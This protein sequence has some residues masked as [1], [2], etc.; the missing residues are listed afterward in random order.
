MPDRQL[1]AIMFTDIMGYTSLMNE[2]E[3]KALQIIDKN[4]KLHELSLKTYHGRLIKKMGD[5]TL[6]CFSSAIEAVQ[7]AISIQNEVEKYPQLNLRIGIH[8]GD[9]VIQENDIYGDGVNIAARIESLTGCGEIYISGQVYDS[10]RNHKEFRCTSIGER[11]LKNVGNPVMIYKVITSEKSQKETSNIHEITWDKSIVV[12][13]FDDLS[14]GKDNEYFSDGLIEE[15][16]TM[17]SQIHSLRVISRTSALMY[18]GKV[19]SVTAIGKELNVQHVLE[20]SVRK[21]GNHLKITAQ[22]I[23]A[24]NDNHLWAKSYSGTLDDIFQIQESVSRSIVDSLEIKLLKNENQVL[25]NPVIQDARAYEYYLK[26]RSEILK[27]TEVG[28]EYAINYLNAA[29]DIMGDNIMLIEGLGLAYFNYA[30]VTLKD[31]KRYLME[32]R[33]CAEQA[34]LLKPDAYQGYFLTGMVEVLEGGGCATAYPYL[35]KA[36]KIAPQDPELLLWYPLVLAF[37][38]KTEEALP[39]MDKLLALDPLVST[40]YLMLA[41]AQMFTGKIEASLSSFQRC[42]ELNPLDPFRFLYAYAL[43]YNDQHKEV[44]MVELDLA[45]HSPTDDFSTIFV[46]MLQ[47][48]LKNNERGIKNLL[49]SSIIAKCKQDCEFSWLVADC[50]ALVDNKNEALNWLEQSVDR[51]F[52]NYQFFYNFDPFMEN[53]KK[54][55]RFEEIM[56]KAKRILDEIDL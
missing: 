9:V 10:V 3:Q 21:A 38:G 1:S 36:F 53:L 37:I 41:K 5:G 27:F 51:G 19:K 28:C 15:I 35:K 22:L 23:D 45:R 25:S 40:N 26:A 24:V 54:E 11:N 52:L 49:S 34:I 56:D 13:P 50:Y 31:N 6:C 32:C 2:D 4:D 30:N 44:D 16:I 46:K 7:C 43:A 48:A 47:F 55:K 14:P 12:L 8:L 39:L 17:L 33:K 18:K 20:G 29:K 42:G